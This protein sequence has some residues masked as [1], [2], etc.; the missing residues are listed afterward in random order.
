MDQPGPSRLRR[1]RPLRGAQ[2]CR[3]RP[4]RLAGNQYRQPSVQRPNGRPARLGRPNGIRRR[5][6]RS[7]HQKFLLRLTRGDGCTAR[8]LLPRLRWA[9]DRGR[10]SSVVGQPCHRYGHAGGHGPRAV[11]RW[12]H[13]YRRLRPGRRPR[14]HCAGSK[15]LV[16]HGLLLGFANLDHPARISTARQLGRRGLAGE[17][18]RPDRRRQP[19]DQFCGISQAVR[20]EQRFFPALGT[21]CY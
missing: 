11:Y 9:G 20:P 17:R 4:R 13:Q 3:L 16:Q 5:A 8:Q 15:R 14:C 21:A 19:R 7:D 18:G 2:Y 1:P 6:P 10:K 12:V